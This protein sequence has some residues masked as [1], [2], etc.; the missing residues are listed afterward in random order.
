MYLSV[1]IEEYFLYWTYKH[2]KFLPTTLIGKMREVLLNGN[3]PIERRNELRMSTALAQY[4]NNCRMLEPDNQKRK[5]A[6][7]L[8]WKVLNPSRAHLGSL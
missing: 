1:I 4:V 7:N 3:V 5:I 8:T 6:E 2:F